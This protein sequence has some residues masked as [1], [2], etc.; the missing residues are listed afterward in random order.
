MSVNSKKFK[1]WLSSIVNDLSTEDTKNIIY[2]C[3]YGV[4][5]NDIIKLMLKVSNENTRFIIW[6]WQT[7]APL[8]LTL[9]ILYRTRSSSP[10]AYLG[11]I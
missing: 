6:F 10:E 8:L 9:S 1:G 3:K 4:E 11:R 2:M 7:F 5:G